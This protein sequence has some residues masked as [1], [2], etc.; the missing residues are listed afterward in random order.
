[1][2]EKGSM[3]ARGLV[4]AAAVMCFVGLASVP[5][6]LAGWMALPNAPVA[7]LRHDDIFFVDSCGVGW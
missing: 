7:I 3:M 5:P 6:A 2:A 4:C 1:M